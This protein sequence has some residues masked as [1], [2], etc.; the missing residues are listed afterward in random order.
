MAE[1]MCQDSVEMNHSGVEDIFGNCSWDSPGFT[2]DRLNKSSDVTAHTSTPTSRITR[3]RRKILNDSFNLQQNEV[4]TEGI[5]DTPKLFFSKKN[6]RS[7][8]SGPL[9]GHEII[10]TSLLTSTPGRSSGDSKVVEYCSDTLDLADSFWDKT[11]EIDALEGNKENGSTSDVPAHEDILSLSIDD[12]FCVLHEAEVSLG[13]NP[14]APQDLTPD[15]LLGLNP[16]FWINAKLTIKSITQLRQ[17]DNAFYIRN[18]PIRF[19]SMIGLV[20]SLQVKDKYNKFMLEDTTGRIECTKWNNYNDSSVLNDI[21]VGKLVHVK[22]KLCTFRDKR[23]IKVY[24]VNALEDFNQLTLHLLQ[25]NTTMMTVYNV[26]FL[27][28]DCSGFVNDVSEKIKNAVQESVLEK[29]PAEDVEEYA[30]LSGVKKWL[31]CLTVI[32]KESKSD[33][34]SKIVGELQPGT[35]I[36]E[37]RKHLVRIRDKILEL[38]TRNPSLKIQG[39]QAAVTRGIAGASYHQITAMLDGL[40]MSGDVYESDVGVYKKM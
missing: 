26:N 11:L 9:K 1:N 8:K 25:C 37:E 28:P 33:L 14:E 7:K 29:G 31:E 5:F 30:E 2:L 22:G 12:Q 36:N 24:N 3:S 15:F 20:T 10:N 35:S 6:K 40:V 34:L 21:D 4:V 38:L 19:I 23:E 32:T 17:G 39:L 27:L 18:H 13:D 16:S